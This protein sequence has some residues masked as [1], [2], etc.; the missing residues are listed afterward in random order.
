MYIR[1]E[2]KDHFPKLGLDNHYIGEGYPLCMDLPNQHWLKSGAKYRLLGSN[3]VPDL[4]TETDEWFGG[5]PKRL[6]LNETSQLANLL[7]NNDVNNCQPT[8]TSFVLPNDI[9]CEELE[10]D[11]LEPRTVEIQGIFFEYVRPACV[12]QLFFNDGKT[13]RKRYSSEGRR[14]CGDPRLSHAGTACCSVNR[15]DSRGRCVQ[16]K[17]IDGREKLSMITMQ[18]FV[19]HNRYL[20]ALPT[21]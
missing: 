8:S 10:C 14:V 3:P 18:T 19:A 13:I 7:C 15:I 1:H 11:I 2:R 6:K 12:N 4:L 16:N 9:A 21:A 5:A 20:F 17:W